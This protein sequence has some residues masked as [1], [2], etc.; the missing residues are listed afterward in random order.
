ML[1][2]LWVITKAVQDRRW[3]GQILG[4]LIIGLSA[5]TYLIAEPLPRSVLIL[6]QSEP[7]SPWGFSFRDSFQSSFREASGD[8]IAIY[9]EILDLGRF[10]GPQ[11][12]DILRTY[13]REKYRDKHIG[14][15]VT[16]GSAALK[17]ILPMREEVWS[18]IQIVAAGLDDVTATQS[19]FPPQ[20]TGTILRLSLRNAVIAAHSLVPGL[21]RI[22]LVGNPYDRSPYFGHFTQELPEFRHDVEFVDLLGLGMAELK[23]RLAALP[24]D[25]AILYSAIYVDGGGVTYIPQEALRAL[26]AVANRPIVIS[27]E[28][29]LG[30]GG[31][32]GYV[33]LAGRVGMDAAQRALRILKGEAASDIPVSVGDFARPIFD[34]RQLQRFGISENSLPAGSEVRFR[35]PSMWEQYRWQMISITAATLILVMMI[36][37]LLF[38]RSRRQAAQLET[39]SRILEVIHLN[40]T[41]TT[42][43]LSASIAH[44]LYQPL[45]AI[46]SNA[47]AAEILLSATSPNLDQVKEILADI[48]RDDERAGDIIKHLRGLLK[49]RSSIELREI[50]LNDAIRAAIYVLEPEAGRRGVVLTSRQMQG[51][52]PVRADQIHLEQVIFNLA[53][54][55]MDAMAACAAHAR[56][57]EVQTAMIG[58][59]EIEVSVLDSGTGIPADKLKNIFETFYTTKPEGTGLGL[60][61]ARTIVETYGGKI[62]AENRSA[63]GSVFR[64]TLP[65]A[66]AHAA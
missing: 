60:S 19:N 39:R 24:S 27:S 34:W 9:V 12:K 62:W 17:A 30:N 55:G 50:D 26:A 32:G 20:A 16:L 41:A 23:V 63:G 64:F 21:K 44:E 40:R 42:G 28:S 8:P 51:A 45:G 37:G 49:K 3:L 54:N 14:V 10:D 13:L 31:T 25:A 22:A 65:V 43:A 15:I 11:H 29:G 52:I 2:M 57:M 58:D 47:E 53:T 6:D 35:P 56:R 5:P 18:G 38:E 33:A 1:A 59:S 61:I 66:K 7:N 4:C 36:L 46:L 48:R